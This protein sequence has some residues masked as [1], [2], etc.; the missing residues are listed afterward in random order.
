VTRTPGGWLRIALAVAAATVLVLVLATDGLA[1]TKRTPAYIYWANYGAA[2]KGGTIGRAKLNGTDAN[3]SFIS[4][5]AGPVG[6]TVHGAYL[7]WSN[8]SVQANS[9]GTTIGRAKL[10]GTDVNQSFVTG[11]DG[12][13]SIVITG[14]YIYWDSRLH[15]TTGELA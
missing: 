12:A 11:A 14:G 6:V 10:N 13:H 1:S 3:Q 8:P 4:G 15:D 9:P 2:G 7:Y 5:A